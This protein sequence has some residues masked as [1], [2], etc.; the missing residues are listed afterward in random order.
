MKHEAHLSQGTI[1]YR[2]D[3]TGEPLLF[4]HGVVVNGE[5]WRK[6]VPR[7]DGQ[8]MRNARL[9]LETAGLNLGEIVSIPSQSVPPDV[10]IAT[11]P[12]AGS[13]APRG[14]PVNLLVS[15]GGTSRTS[16]PEKPRSPRPAV[17]CG[18]DPRSQAAYGQYKRQPHAAVPIASSA[19]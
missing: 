8:S 4:V 11:E 6:V 7:L 19:D 9:E 17:R 14:T 18:T 2:E 5:L 13:T 1:R 16:W 3:G 10:I 15:T 12:S